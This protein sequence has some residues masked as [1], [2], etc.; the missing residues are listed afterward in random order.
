M[1]GCSTILALSTHFGR[2]DEYWG[3]L[4]IFKFHLHYCVCIIAHF[5]I[6]MQYINL[7]SKILGLPLHDITKLARKRTKVH[8][9]LWRRCTGWCIFICCLF[10]TEYIAWLFVL[11][12][13]GIHC[14][15]IHQQWQKCQSEPSEHLRIHPS[16]EWPFIIPLSRIIIVIIGVSLHE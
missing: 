6:H 9:L 13:F 5:H 11:V 14:S 2:S 3:M 16:I 1:V 10:L 7:I 12:R 15:L 4:W 8:C